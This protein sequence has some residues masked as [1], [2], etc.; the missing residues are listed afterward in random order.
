MAAAAQAQIVY[1]G[2]DV[3]WDLF[4]NEA[5]DAGVDHPIDLT[6]V[7]VEVM[8]AT[9]AKPTIAVED[10][11][12]GKATA[13]LTSQQTEKLVSGQSYWFQMRLIYT[14]TNADVFPPV[15]VKVL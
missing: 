2:A 13:C 3:C 5:D 9:M 10:A 15:P 14:P 1:R 8:S 6:G 4:F 11:V 12:G 7:T